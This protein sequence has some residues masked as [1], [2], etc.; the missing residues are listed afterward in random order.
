MGK[1]TSVDQQVMEAALRHP[2]AAKIVIAGEE[3]VF[4]LS[5]YGAKLAREKGHDPIPAIFKTLKRLGPALQKSGLFK[6]GRPSE[7][8]FTLETLLGVLAEAITGEFLD[9]LCLVVWWGLLT[10]Q[11]DTPLA[12]VQTMV[13]PAGLRSIWKEVGSRMVS[14]TKDL[15]EEDQ[16]E[17]VEATEEDAGG[18]SAGG[19]GN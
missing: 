4:L 15:N 8:G 2:E 9:D 10:V 7:D 17:E 19:Q 14:Y 12:V 11:P 18:E 13:T 5:G 16:E 6:D 3:F 1:R